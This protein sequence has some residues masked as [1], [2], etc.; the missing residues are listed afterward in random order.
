MLEDGELCDDEAVLKGPV[1]VEVVEADFA[2]IGLVEAF[3]GG[4]GDAIEVGLGEALGEG[5]GEPVLGVVAKDDGV[6]GELGRLD[7]VEEGFEGLEVFDLF[8]WRKA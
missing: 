8:I 5:L 7:F 2:P 3:A 6:D 1:V 4:D